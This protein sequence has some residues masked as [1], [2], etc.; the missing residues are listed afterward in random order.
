MRLSAMRNGN[1]SDCGNENFFWTTGFSEPQIARLE[2]AASLS[3]NLFHWAILHE[4]L[5]NDVPKT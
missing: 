4:G 5:Q 2:T 3:S 1:A